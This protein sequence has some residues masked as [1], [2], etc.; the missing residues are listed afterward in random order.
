MCR[1]SGLGVAAFFGL[2][3]FRGLGLTSSLGINHGGVRS[4]RQGLRDVIRVQVWSLC[5][6]SGRFVRSFRT[7][8]HRETPEK[9]PY[10]LDSSNHAAVKPGILPSGKLQHSGL[11]S[12]QNMS[13]C[14]LPC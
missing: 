7:T 14:R 1:G 10:H 4:I 8:P 5:G 2:G 13:L 9:Y 12:I 11:L 6:V 3:K